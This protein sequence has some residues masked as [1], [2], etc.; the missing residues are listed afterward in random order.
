MAALYIKDSRVA[1]RAAQFAHRL[2]TT[3]TEAI[4]RALDALEADLAKGKDAQP[5][6]AERIARWRLEHPPLPPTGLAADKDYADWLSGEE[7]VVD[8]FR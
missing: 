3:K 7:D 1:E 6:F 8:P 5:G 2:G 4:S